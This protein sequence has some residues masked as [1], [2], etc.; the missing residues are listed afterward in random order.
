MGEYATNT[1]HPNHIWMDFQDG[2]LPLIELSEFGQ[3]PL[4][5]SGCRC[6]GV[7]SMIGLPVGL[8]LRIPRHG[9]D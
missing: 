6:L 2:D 4:L 7:A 5:Q 8:Q 9:E 3:P 1:L